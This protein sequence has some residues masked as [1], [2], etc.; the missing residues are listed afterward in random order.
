[1]FACSVL[2][3]IVSMLL[4]LCLASL[5]DKLLEADIMMDDKLG[6]WHLP[7]LFMDVHGLLLA[8][9]WNTEYKAP[10]SF[11]SHS[12]NTLLSFS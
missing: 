9:A 7:Y 1:M 11:L 2:Y 10:S 12:I 6:V 3:H 8:S 5:C 4:V